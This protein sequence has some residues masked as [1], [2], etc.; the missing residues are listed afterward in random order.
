ML[1]GSYWSTVYFVKEVLKSLN[2]NKVKLIIT[3]GNL[4]YIK[5]DFKDAIIDPELT[6][7]GMNVLYQETI[8]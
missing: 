7:K 5:E 8:K 1:H 6:L 2:N 3:G 4:R